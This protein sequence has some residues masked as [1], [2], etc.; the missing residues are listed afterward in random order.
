MFMQKYIV[1]A[2]FL[3]VVFSL[4]A[5]TVK[6]KKETARIKSEYADGYEV[7]LDG[8]AQ[9]VESAMGKYMKTLGKTKEVD[10]YVAV[11]EPVIDGRKYTLPVYAQTK[12]LGNMVSAWM[13]IK[14][15][16]WPEGDAAR[17]S[18]DLEK[19]LYDFGVQFHRNKIQKQID[20][21]MQAAQAVERQQQKLSNQ[22]RSL[23]TK[24]EDNKR[25]KIQLEKSLVNNAAEL[26]FLTGK[27][28]K[29]THDQDSVAL[30]GEQIKK[31]IEMHKERQRKVN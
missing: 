29:N 18:N 27:L 12:Q 21:S 1:S 11:N 2:C 5:Q 30:A 22:N 13:G 8:T 16:E 31:V 14:T 19:M 24:I 6:V 28:A 17:V 20:E 25:E 26:E 23:N 10:I 7:A 9:E 4:S 15:K 3:M